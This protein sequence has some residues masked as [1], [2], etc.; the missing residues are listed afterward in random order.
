MESN[1]SIVKPLMEVM[2]LFLRS[3]QHISDTPPGYMVTLTL[4]LSAARP[5][6]RDRDRDREPL[7]VATFYFAFVYFPAIGITTDA[8]G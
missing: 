4:C 1:Q 8:V 2:A 5:L 7:G 3:Y 6:A